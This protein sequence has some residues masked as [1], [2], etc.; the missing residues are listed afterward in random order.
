[1]QQT[2]VLVCDDSALMRQQLKKIIESDPEFCVVGAAR[3]GNDA[4]DKARDLRPDVVTM[5]INMPGIDGITALQLIVE[6]KIAPVVM[7][8]SLTQQGAE[9]TLQAM[10]LGAFDYIAKPGGTVTANMSS[11][12]RE[13]TRKLRAA[14]IT[15]TLDRLSRPS[16]DSQTRLV[17]AQ[18]REVRGRTRRRSLASGIGYRAVAIGISTGGPKTLMEVL[19]FI[20]ADL[21][22]A[23]FV[24]QHMPPTFTCSF[25]KRINDNCPMRCYETEAGMRVEPNTIYLAKGGHHLTLFKK[26]NNEILIRAPKRPEHL[27]IPSV[28]IMMES[29]LSVFGSDTV[30]VLMTGMGDDGA[31]TMVKI[32][33][34]E[35]ATIAESQ[36]S[37][38]V[39]GMPQEAIN[40]G[41][42]EVVAP[43]WDIA[44]E[45][46][47]AVG[48][49]AF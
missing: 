33:E 26:E 32:R 16:A 21:N 15:G 23:I 4:V 49:G 20:P 5:D 28:D 29:V 34:A 30:G 31:N 1:M 10:A 6:E 37:A 2:R 42:A 45:I 14:T 46:I 43:S 27:F 41:G 47:K 18:Q 3:D 39:F 40:R 36:E 44:G 24:V 8:S 38:I 19:P 48:G 12:A 7:V 13:I 17:R 35:G 9:A 22:A 25:A 11:V